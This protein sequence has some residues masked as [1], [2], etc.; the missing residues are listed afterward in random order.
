VPEVQQVVVE[1]DG[2]VLDQ[3]AYAVQHGKYHDLA[4]DTGAL[5]GPERPVA[6]T[7]VGRDRGDGVAIVVDVT[8]PT[9]R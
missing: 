5:P 7:Q 2:G 9:P 6:V 3:Q 4:H 1:P 8:G